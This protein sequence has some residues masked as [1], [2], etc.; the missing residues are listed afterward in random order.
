[1]TQIVD[2][3]L[4]LNALLKVTKYQNNKIL[5]FEIPKKNI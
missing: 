3:K 2:Y 4:I 5:R 1:M